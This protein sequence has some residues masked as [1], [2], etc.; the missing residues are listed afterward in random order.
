[1]RKPQPKRN[2][3]HEAPRLLSLDEAKR[4]RGGDAVPAMPYTDAARI[5]RP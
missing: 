4:V 5:A 1:M 2:P 3:E